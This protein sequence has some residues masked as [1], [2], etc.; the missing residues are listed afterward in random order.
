MKRIILSLI[1]LSLSIVNLY[2]EEIDP[3]DRLALETLSYFTPLNMVINSIS[4]EEVFVET[5]NPS[6]FKTGM[7]L[8][9][10]RQGEPYYHPIT[11]AEIA[12]TESK[13]GTVEVSEVTPKGARLKVLDGRLEQADIVRITS[14]KIR[15]IFYHSKNVPWGISEEYFDTLKRTERFELY[16]VSPLI[17]DDKTLI[18]E[19]S[20]MQAELIIAIESSETLTGTALKERLIWVSD[21]KVFAELSVEIERGYVRELQ[22]GEEFFSPKEKSDIRVFDLP[23]LSRVLSVGDIDGDK[24]YEIALSTGKSI[25]FYTAGKTLKPA[26]SGLE[27]HAPKRH[28]YVWIECPDIDGDGLLEVLAVSLSE[29]NVV[30][31]LYGFRDGKLTLLSE[32][33]FFVR[34][35]ENTLYGQR[36]SKT[37]GFKGEVFRVKDSTAIKL[38]KGI[39]LYDFVY[40]GE[41]ILAYDSR[42]YISLYDEKGSLL[43]ISTEGLGG[44]LRVFQKEPPT[45]M[46]PKEEW[47]IKD[48]LL[49]I[50]GSV[51]AI[52]RHRVSETAPG[53]GFTH[54]E[55]R[56]LRLNENNI[57]QK[58][59]IE[60]V[61]GKALDMAVIGD[62]IAVLSEEMKLSNIIKG[63]GIMGTKLYIYPLRKTYERAK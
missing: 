11:K 23:F 44:P 50:D 1:F 36:F 38:P 33:D 19:A 63:Y 20:K 32:W 30:S 14:A 4:P 43:W 60:V 58:S 18:E 56:L 7:R 26:L 34:A 28:E 21:G 46:A 57:E 29:N 3:F 62:S 52:K 31:R 39:C 2:G 6:I 9:V 35:I 10:F 40:I 12:R 24:E 61:P 51:I 47:S 42:G 53:F 37:E 13:V 59:L 16:G 41:M 8:S 45:E 48:R 22:V 25:V 27:I 17:S 15:A 55:I 49:V 5:D 54:S